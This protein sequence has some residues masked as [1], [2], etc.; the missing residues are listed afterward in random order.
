MISSP[1]QAAAASTTAASAPAE[2]SSNPQ[3]AT[4]PTGYCMMSNSPAT[5]AAASGVSCGAFGRLGGALMGCSVAS[6][7]APASTSGL[8]TYRQYSSTVKRYGSSAVQSGVL[9]GSRVG[10]NMAPATTMNQQLHY[11]QAVQQTSTA[12]Q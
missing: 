4:Y 12:A 3:T 8:T 6:T 1:S 5:A 7:L 10:F 9:L 2:I 11:L